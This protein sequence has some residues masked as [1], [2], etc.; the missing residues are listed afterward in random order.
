MMVLLASTVHA[1]G[2]LLATTLGGRPSWIA[3]SGWAIAVAALVVGIVLRSAHGTLASGA[4]GLAA[5]VAAHGSTTGGAASLSRDVLET[6]LLVAIGATVLVLSVGR[7]SRTAS[8]PATAPQST[9]E[10]PIA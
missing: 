1:T 9:L 10:S 8:R 7:E 4:I 2:L 5:L 6:S 3:F